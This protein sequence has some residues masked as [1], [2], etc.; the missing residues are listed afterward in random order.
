[1]NPVTKIVKYFSK[2]AR[3]KRAV[4]FRKTFP[5]GNDTRILDLGSENGSNIHDYLL[6]T[7]V[8]SKNVYIADIELE[9]INE[10]SKLFGFNPVLINESGALPYP[11]GFFDIVFCS[12][13]I[14]HVTVPKEDVWKLYSGYDFKKESFKKQKELAE[15]IQRL[16]KQYFVQTPYKHF[17][18]ESHSWLPFISWLPRWLLIAV[19]RFTNVFW[20]KKTNPDWYLLNKQEMSKMFDNANIIEEKV[21]GITKSIIAVKSIKEEVLKS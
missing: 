4:I 16:G 3:E 20:V 19:L 8:S 17:P 21:L 1:M 15:E 11:D 7:K 2:R 18:I 10:G 14:E 6:G 13:V 12:S 5:I 9:A